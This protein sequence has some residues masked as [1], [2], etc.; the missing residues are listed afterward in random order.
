MREATALVAALYVITYLL[1]Q[2]RR[3]RSR[4]RLVVVCPLRSEAVP[5]EIV[6]RLG[7]PI[8]AGEIDRFPHAELTVSY[9]TKLPLPSMGGRPIFSPERSPSSAR[10]AT[11]NAAVL[12]DLAL[13]ALHVLRPRSLLV[14]FRPP[15]KDLTPGRRISTAEADVDVAMYAW[16]LLCRLRR[17]SR[18]RGA[19]FTLLFCDREGAAWMLAR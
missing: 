6:E 18:Y 7:A 5:E 13:E 12:Y 10:E 2:A 16:E 15:P 17:Y 1:A 3:R 14:D 9:L 19:T 4:G 8:P 11:W